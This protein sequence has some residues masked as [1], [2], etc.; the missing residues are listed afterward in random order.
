MASTSPE[1]AT[2]SRHLAYSDGGAHKFW[3]IELNGCSHTVTFGRIGTAGQTQTKE[4]AD[5]AAARKA[6]DKLVAEKLKKGYV[7]ESASASPASAAGNSTAATAKAKS[8]KKSTKNAA[9]EAATSVPPVS[10]PAIGGPAVDLSTK[11]EIALD[12]EDWGRAT[13]RPRQRLER[14]EP[15][16]FDLEDCVRR[17]SKLKTTSYG[18]NVRWDSLGLP[19]AISPEE[20]HFWLL[21]M[22]TPRDRS[23]SPKA[24]AEELAK[25]KFTGKVPFE[26]ARKLIGQCR[27]E[28]PDNLMLALANLLPPER[29]IDFILEP[30]RTSPS[31]AQRQEVFELLSGLQRHVL[32][33]LSEDEI[34]RMR[35]RIRRNWDPTRESTVDFSPLPV[36]IYVAAVLGMHE[37]VY[38]VTSHWEDDRYQ[39][40]DYADHWQRPQLIVF[41]LGSPSLVESEW[42]RLKLKVHSPEDARALL[43]CTEYAALDCLAND[44]IAE[45]NRERCESLLKVLALV[46]APSAAVPILECRLYSKAPA[47]ARRW[48]DTYVGHSV[49]GLLETAAGQGRL[50]EAALE[51]LRDARRK[52]YAEVIAAAIQAASNQQAGARIQAEVL[53]REEKIYEPLDTATTPQWLR[54]ALD[55][56]G[57][58]KV[59][60]LPA[61]A[62]AATLPPLLVGDRRL[63]DE[64]VSLLLQVLA[65]TP[66]TT[67]HPL[68]TAVREHVDEQ[69]RDAFAWK[70][71]LHW[72]DDGGPPAQKWAMGTIGHLGSDGCVLKLTPLIRVWPGESQH[73]RAVFG[74]ECLRAIGS[75]VALM[76]LS[77]IAQKLKFKG[78]KSKAEQ[79]VAEIA[80]EKGLTR[81]ELEDRVIPD[82]GLD[83]NGRREFSFGPR[84]FSF[85]LGS[86]LKA[87]VRDGEGKV[88]PDLPKPGS[89]DDEAIANASVAAW[90][91]LKKQIKEV[92]TIQA[93]RL[94]NAMVTGRRWSP[95]DFET[96]LVRHPLMT[97]L[98]QKLI[99]AAYD[100][101]GKRTAT[102]R[103]TEERDYADVKDNPYDL[104]NVAQVGIVH[105]LDLTPDER[106]AWG[107]VLSDYE[108]V[109]P[110]P[111]LGREVYSLEPGEESQTELKRFSELK[112]VAPTLV[113]TLEKLGWTRG[114]AMDGGCFD[115]HSK[116]FPGAD[117][118]AVVTYEGNVAMGYIDPDEM[119]TL[120]TVIFCKGMREPN[121]FGEGLDK[122]VALNKV[123]PIVISEVLA[124]MHVLKSKAK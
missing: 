109:T 92:A 44:I 68:F 10:T 8:S 115:E 75:N 32:P 57:S 12:P 64:Q 99:W 54:D 93:S 1:T 65:A 94:E 50:A 104:A 79:F 82:C 48:L 89:R 15:R 98:V 87:M 23:T 25:K 46:H 117:V 45:N 124:D 71:F 19:A 43:A 2:V 100:A 4:F 119:L 70:A 22:T 105:A 78:L 83:E 11:P 122:K 18:W 28:L 16:P 61:W 21:A 108:I 121:C 63:N 102:F 85:L 114:C 51:Y 53:D 73:A 62:S 74:L 80:K 58:I 91:L 9:E 97:H 101:K 13:F 40:D 31:W 33:Y 66:I 30:S 5:D 60:P 69:S 7:D 39:Q 41:G 88:R 52:G 110:F 49:Q 56:V 24:V 26:Q 86:D 111:Q 76:Q 95:E 14:N 116:Q 6:F 120:G 59:R 72:Q 34:E 47:L 106:A 20:A 17:M 123:P 27:G 42:R 84:S 36:E 77:A 3:K 113:F 37:E 112:L 55:V 96:L 118:T 107:E 103:I 29:L 90:K 67:R 81:A 38:E 35:E